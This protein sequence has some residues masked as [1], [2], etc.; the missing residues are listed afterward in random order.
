MR[1][2]AA[3]SFGTEMRVD[4]NS[5][6]EKVRH[7]GGGLMSIGGIRLPKFGTHPLLLHA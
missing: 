3:V 4:S 2:S 1:E 6:S 5:R 7:Q